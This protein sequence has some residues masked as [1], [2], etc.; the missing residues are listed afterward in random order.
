M[1]LE[2]PAT[3][4]NMEQACRKFA[5]THSTEQSPGTISMFLHGTRAERAFLPAFFLT[6]RIFR[7]RMRFLLF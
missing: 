2:T 6:V 3:I 5:G 7:K 4:A 1:R